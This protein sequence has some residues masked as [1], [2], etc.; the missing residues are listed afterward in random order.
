M[1]STNK[2]P[3]FSN[4]KNPFKKNERPPTVITKKGFVMF[5]ENGEAYTPPIPP[6]TTYLLLTEN[7]D[8]LLTE[9]GDNLEIQY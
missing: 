1:A 3:F 6:L 5:E 4:S 7:G 9:N 2:Y 8:T